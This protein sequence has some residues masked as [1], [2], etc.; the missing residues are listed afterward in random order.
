M[1]ELGLAQ[2]TLDLALD[3]ARQQGA[4]RIVAFKLRIGDWSGVVVEA[5]VFALATIIEGTIAEGADIQWETVKPAVRCTQCGVEYEVDSY[6][7]A[8]AACGQENY[9]LC[10]GQEIELLTIEVD[11]C[12]TIADAKQ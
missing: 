5:M 3:I 9:Q 12:V 11:E 10:R 7:Y 6:Q 4:N 1:H 2:Q 8:C